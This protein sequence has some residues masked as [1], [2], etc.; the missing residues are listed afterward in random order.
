MVELAV[1][2]AAVT[3]AALGSDANTGEHAIVTKTAI[4]VDFIVLPPDFREYDRQQ[5][6]AQ[7]CVR[8]CGGASECECMTGSN[9]AR[10]SIT[11]K[12][13]C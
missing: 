13:V 3:G 7:H 4:I 6:S 8:R 5:S 9:A 12:L 1:I 2:S 10:S 11:T